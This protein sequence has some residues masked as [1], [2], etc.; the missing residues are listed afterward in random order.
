MVYYLPT[1]GCLV[2]L[3]PVGATP[4]ETPDASAD[5]T[6]GAPGGALTWASGEGRIGAPAADPGAMAGGWSTDE[7]ALEEGFDL[8]AELARAIGYPVEAL[9]SRRSSR[10][11][12]ARSTERSVDDSSA[13][14]R[15]SRL[16]RANSDR[17]RGS[18]CLLDIQPSSRFTGATLDRWAIFLRSRRFPGHESRTRACRHARGLGRLEPGIDEATCKQQRSQ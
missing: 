14:R 16:R 10:T 11:V 6:I 3:E 8:T 7:P 15:E 13:W 4:D 9:E 1:S 5:A 12:S 2:A 17:G 18:D